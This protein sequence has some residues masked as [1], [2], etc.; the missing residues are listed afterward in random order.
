MY[1]CMY[2]CGCMDVACIMLLCV[3]AYMYAYAR[4]WQVRGE[5]DHD[6]DTTKEVS[7]ALEVRLR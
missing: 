1:V 5:A 6:N 4:A 7:S 3:S 2:V